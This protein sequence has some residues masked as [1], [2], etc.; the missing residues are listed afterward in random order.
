VPGSETIAAL[1]SASGD[2]AIAI[3]RLSGPEAI[4]IAASL[5]PQSALES[6]TGFNAADA[7][8]DIPGVGSVP[9]RAYIFK[10]PRSYTTED[11]A[12][13]HL[14]GSPL[15]VEKTLLALADKGAR[16]AEPGEFTRRAYLGG[17]IDLVQ[18]EAV[19]AVI[20][21]RNTAELKSAGRVLAG[22]LSRKL[23]SISDELKDLLALAE[24]SMDFSDHDIEPISSGEMKRRIGA[25]HDLLRDC[26]GF[27]EEVS[28]GAMKVLICGM[29]NVGKSSLFNKL[30]GTERVIVSGVPG[31]TRDVISASARFEDVEV[32]LLDA[33]GKKS[34]DG[35]VERFAMSALDDTLSDAD[36]VIFLIEAN[37][38]PGNE[39]VIFF[40]S[41]G[42]GKLLV[43]N[44]CDLG[45]SD[46]LPECHKIS[47]R[48]G[49][50][51]PELVKLIEKLL[52]N[53]VERYPDEMM[54]T[55][56]QRNA[57][58]R[59]CEAL[60][61]AGA[62]DALELVAQDMREAMGALGEISGEFVA[63]DILDRIFSRF[64]IGK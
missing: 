52:L 8:L 38:K 37:G 9:V 64:C 49:E 55:V 35:E 46:E 12:E 27:G 48:T 22:L 33:A 15:L 7:V 56:R 4:R 34:P 28:H 5:C 17:R 20:D 58:R 31:T 42:S 40:E 10:S 59:A 24:A 1:S 43:A 50:G 14:P 3:V 62:T 29:P 16:L 11:V 47:C 36:A 54:L 21:A 23:S 53:E 51:I 41:I 32:L 30:L 57:V 6:M 13:L 60:E 61:R 19:S 18:A 25:T 2:S 44:K 63:G 45:V 39:E 26:A